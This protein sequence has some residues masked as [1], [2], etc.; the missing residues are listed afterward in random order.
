MYPVTGKQKNVV[1]IEMQGNRDSDF[2]RANRANKE[3][4][5]LSVV[6]AQG[7]ENHKP[8]NGYTWDHQDDYI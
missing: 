8:P 3:A 7:L 1:V 6:Q 4:G 2:L 5:L